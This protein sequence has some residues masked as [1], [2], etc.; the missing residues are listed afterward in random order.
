MSSSPKQGKA[1]E[2]MKMCEFCLDTG[3]M[4]VRGAKGL[5]RCVWCPKGVNFSKGEHSEAM[6]DFVKEKEG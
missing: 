6:K 1:L 5:Q 3:F 4:K 2:K